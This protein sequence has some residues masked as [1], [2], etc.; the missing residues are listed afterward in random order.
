[1]FFIHIYIL[2]L[3]LYLCNL[4]A[5]TVIADEYVDK[6]FGSGALK[7]TPAHDMND[8]ELGKKFN[9]PLINIMNKDASLNEAAGARYQGLDRFA[10]REQ[11]WRDLEEAGLAIKREPHLQRVP[12]SQ[13]GGEVIEPMVSAQWFVRMEDMA[14]KAVAAVRG[15]QIQILPDRFEKVWYGWLENIHDWCI[16]RQL[17]WGHRIPVYYVQSTATTAT[18]ANGRNGVEYIVARSAAEARKVAEEKYGAGVTLR[19]DEDVLDTW[20]R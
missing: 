7:I 6:E 19:Q 16:S 14:A 12:R 11:I 9:L 17:W 20:F 10:A 4:S 3:L 2:I 5:M 13:R 15:G 18:T 1:M 8:Y